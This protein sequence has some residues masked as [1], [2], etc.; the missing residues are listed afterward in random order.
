MTKDGNQEI[1]KENIKKKDIS[2]KENAKDASK[3]KFNFQRNNPPISNSKFQMDF[4]SDDSKPHSPIKLLKLKI[5][6][7]RNQLSLLFFLKCL[8]TKHR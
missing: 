2:N 3:N 1:K 5:C 8:N 6:Y 7:C 4:D